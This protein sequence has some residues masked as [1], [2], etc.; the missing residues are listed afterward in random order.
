MELSRWLATTT[1]PLRIVY[2]A[3]DRI[4]PD[5]ERTVARVKR[6]LPHA[7]VTRIE[8]CGHFLQEDRPAEVAEA[9]AAFFR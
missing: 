5:I 1:M 3:K 4:L 8:D 2:G 9:L 7:E 6:E